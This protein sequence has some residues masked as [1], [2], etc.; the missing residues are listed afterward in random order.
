[1][2][3]MASINSHVVRAVRLRVNSSTD[4]ARGAARHPG[5]WTTR[6]QTKLA[7]RLFRSISP[8]RSV[9][10]HSARVHALGTAVRV[11]SAVPFHPSSIRCRI[12]P[13]YGRWDPCLDLFDSRVL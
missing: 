5:A 2:T 8:A 12:P 10:T 13:A 11:H 7:G 3:A 4:V 6:V 9:A 1:M